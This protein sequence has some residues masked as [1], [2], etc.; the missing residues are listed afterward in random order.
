MRSDPCRPWRL[1]AWGPRT[2]GNSLCRCRRRGWRRRSLCSFGWSLQEKAP[3]PLRSRF[4][5]TFWVEDFFGLGYFPIQMIDVEQQHGRGIRLFEFFVRF[6][7]PALAK[8][9]GAVDVFVEEA[10]LIGNAEVVEHGL[11]HI[12]MRNQDG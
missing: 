10:V 3:T 9:L 2:E 6:M 11:N 5:N 12:Q 4:G 1:T 7:L 8:I